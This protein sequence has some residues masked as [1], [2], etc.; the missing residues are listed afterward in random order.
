MGGLWRRK[1]STISSRF[2]VSFWGAPKMLA[3]VNFGRSVGFVDTT[4]AAVAPDDDA[5]ASAANG[6]EEG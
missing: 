1:E 5:A 3:G 2:G 4:G 6:S